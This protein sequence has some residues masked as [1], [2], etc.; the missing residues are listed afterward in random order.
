MLRIA[1]AVVDGVVLP[2]LA[3]LVPGPLSH[4][5]WLTLACRLLRLYVST[6]APSAELL[7]LA[8]F[9]MKVYVPQWF[10]IKRS[11]S[12]TYGARHV[13]KAIERSRFVFF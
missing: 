9:V 6:E 7:T 10:D 3:D 4:A 2:E 13:Y 12:C 5:R 8:T 1:H 11:S